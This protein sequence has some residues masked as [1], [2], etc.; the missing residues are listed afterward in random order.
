MFTDI[1]NR[2]SYAVFFVY[3]VITS[4]NICFQGEIIKI[5]ILQ[6]KLLQLFLQKNPKNKSPVNFDVDIS[7]RYPFSWKE[8][9]ASNIGYRKCHMI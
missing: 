5:T 4:H 6:V 7:N 3:T 1:R 2:M 8:S 9:H